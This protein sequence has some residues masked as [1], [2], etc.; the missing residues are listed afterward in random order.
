MD[1]SFESHAGVLL[2][3]KLKKQQKKRRSRVNSLPL[4]ALKSSLQVESETD[5]RLVS[6]HSCELMN[7]HTHLKNLLNVHEF[8]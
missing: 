5:P 4:P 1:P 3:A 6:I 2:Q 7:F 8:T